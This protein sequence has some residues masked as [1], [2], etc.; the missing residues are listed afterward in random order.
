MTFLLVLCFEMAIVASPADFQRAQDAFNQRQ[1]H[2][3]IEILTPYRQE[4]NPAIHEYLAA[5]YERTG[6]L[7]Q[8]F[9]HWQEAG[10]LYQSDGHAERAALSLLSQA[11][12]SVEM[13]QPQKALELLEQSSDPLADGVR[14]NALLVSGEYER[15]IEAYQVALS[16]KGVAEEP[17]LAAL[18]NLGEAYQN[19]ALRWQRKAQLLR[20][21]QEESEARQ[22]EQQSQLLRQLARKTAQVAWQSAQ[23]VTSPNALQAGIAWLPYLSE[24]ERGE[25]FKSLQARLR[26][27]PPS[28]QT[29]N[30]WLS[31]APLTS[32]P[33]PILE[34]ALQLARSLEDSFGISLAAGELGAFY[35]RQHNYSLALNYT[36]Q[37]QQ[38]AYT[39][40]AYEQLY[41]W[42]WQ[43]GRIDQAIAAEEAAIS[44][45][46]RSAASLQRIRPE[47]AAASREIQF[48]FQEQIEPIYRGL[49]SLLLNNPSSENLKESLNLFDRF[50]LAQLENLFADTCFEDLPNNHIEQWLSQE[51]IALIVPI[52][53]ENRLHLILRLPGGS[54][55]HRVQLIDHQDFVQRIKN[56]KS[57]LKNISDNQYLTLSEYFYDRL[58]APLELAIKKAHPNALLFINDGLLKNVP[59][60]ALYQT[61]KQ[62][63]LIQQ[64]PVFT[65]LGLNFLTPSQSLEFKPLL[66]GLSVPRPPLEV[67]LPLVREEVQKIQELLGGSAFLNQDFTVPKLQETV[68][69]L[70]PTILH[71]A[72]HGQFTGSLETSFLQAY[73]QVIAID[74]LDS[75]L[76]KGEPLDLLT[77][78]ACE[79]SVGNNYS[80]LG[81]AGTAIRA[82][83]RS[84]LGTFWQVQDDAS[85]RVVERFYAN[86]KSGVSKAKALQL[87]QIQEIENPLQHPRNWAAFTLIGL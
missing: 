35:E 84:V 21:E 44:A 70:N 26:S 11:Q 73:D 64:Y 33:Q 9:F 71:L 40:L 10:R 75:L 19:L 76:I 17:R 32:H 63:F 80:V 46:R 77:L 6:Q 51:N 56:W 3:T 18:N 67:A 42:Q 22:L 54:Y 5:S 74:E 65:A 59:L 43:E 57:D 79:T 49:L 58:Y 1:Y 55:H 52:I 30:L 47:M 78:S 39:L 28:H 16:H 12:L 82:G 45:Y 62:E 29:V 7:D 2:Q 83:A 66:F 31:L 20:Q 81:L 34:T 87:A 38:A 61:G 27:L 69:R 4:S 53:L 86:L 14:G 60:S 13:G 24:G 68:A 37:A 85:L 15:A 8:A 48:D 50:Q 25:S 23:D 41:R 36:E 72:T